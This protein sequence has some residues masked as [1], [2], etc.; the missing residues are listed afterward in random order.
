MI[1][2]VIKNSDVLA[3]EEKLKSLGYEY[4]TFSL[5]EGNL[6]NAKEHEL[7]W[8]W[9][10]SAHDLSEET[11]R[12]RLSVYRLLLSVDVEANSE[13]LI[14]GTAAM[15]PTQPERYVKREL[16][17]FFEE[18]ENAELVRLHY[19]NYKEPVSPYE[20]NT[21]EFLPYVVDPDRDNNDPYTWGN[22]AFCI[23][24]KKEVREKLAQFISDYPLGV[25]FL[26]ELLSATDRM[27]AY[28]PTRNLFYH[29]ESV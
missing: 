17:K 11:T 13:F 12:L 29:K 1:C 9:K 8:R 15:C 23:K 27:S 10:P 28:L 21:L 6:P 7:E 16:S 20:S 18:N 2:W 22:Q 3:G 26:V 25:D 19:D 24:N 4:H 14:F 5:Q